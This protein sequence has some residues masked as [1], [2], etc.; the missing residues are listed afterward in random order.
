[1]SKLRFRPRATF[2]ADLK[3]LARLDPTIIDDIRDAIDEIL[4]TGTLPKEYGDHPLKRRL[5]G[6]REFH[7][8]NTPK[9]VQ[10]SE[11]NDVLVIWYVER[12]DL[13]AVAVRAGSHER[14]FHDQNASRKLKE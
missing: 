5:A 10:P 12:H 7:V 14:L 9:G 3:R 4:E 2:N 8:R 13:V 6:Y 1:M 11:V